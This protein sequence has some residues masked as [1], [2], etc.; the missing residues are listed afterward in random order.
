M[1]L[2]VDSVLKFGVTIVEIVEILFYTCIKDK[3]IKL[4]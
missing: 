1:L 2:I 3:F 4:S